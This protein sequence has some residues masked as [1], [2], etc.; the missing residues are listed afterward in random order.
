MASLVPVNLSLINDSKDQCSVVLDSRPL[1][2]EACNRSIKSYSSSSTLDSILIEH[3]NSPPLPALL[4]VNVIE[5]YK[6]PADVTAPGWG[7]KLRGTTSQATDDV[8]VYSCHVE[9]V[10]E[11]GAAKVGARWLVYATKSNVVVT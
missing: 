4:H 11:G 7:V 1:S 8:K 10:Q 9:S 3:S 2:P 5:L 6:R